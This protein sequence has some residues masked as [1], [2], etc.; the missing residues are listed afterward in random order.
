[1]IIGILHSK[2]LNEAI[3]VI[4]QHPQV[5]EVSNK[6]GVIDIESF[7]IDAVIEYLDKEHGL[8]LIVNG[9]NNFVVAAQINEDL[10]ER[11]AEAG[12]KVAEKAAESASGGL[13][14]KTKD[15]LQKKGVIDQT[16]SEKEEESKEEASE[17]A[18]KGQEEVKKTFA[19]KMRDVKE[20]ADAS[21]P[22]SL[23]QMV[24]E[25]PEIVKLFDSLPDSIKDTLRSALTQD[26][27]GEEYVRVPKSELEEE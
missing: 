12:A 5:I 18:E 3:D 25:D 23:R 26:E 10:A 13:V 24:E 17:V 19:D 6:G 16:K 27:G 15:F 1:M 22:D 7:D 2:R 8:H 11:V 4:E 14:S 9:D 20:L 21:N